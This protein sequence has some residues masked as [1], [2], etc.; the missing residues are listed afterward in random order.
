MAPLFARVRSR[1]VRAD[2]EQFI[3]Q[4]CE[5]LPQSLLPCRCSSNTEQRIEFIDSSVRLD[6]ESI[7]E[8][9]LPTHERRLSFIAGSCVDPHSGGMIANKKKPRQAIVGACDVA[10]PS[11]RSSI[12]QVVGKFLEE[13]NG[14][15]NAAEEIVQ[16][17][18]LV[19][20]VRVFIR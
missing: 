18:M 9:S 19:G 10:L 4:T 6:T 17:D 2:D 7:L 11:S 12:L 13:M 1:E 8:D 14:R 16:I 3:L 15:S 20:C 5:D